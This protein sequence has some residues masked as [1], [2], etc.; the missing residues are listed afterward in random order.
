MAPE[1]LR[2][3][4]ADARSDV[5]S[6][7]VVLHHAVSGALPFQGA[8]G[9][10]LSAAILRE[11][12]AALPPTAPPALRSVLQRCL[13]KDPPQRYQTASE[14]RAALDLIGELSSGSAVAAAP[15]P[16]RGRPLLVAAAAAVVALL[17]VAAWLLRPPRPA[18]PISHRL[19]SVFPGSHSAATFSPDG[20]MIAFL[21]DASGTPQVWVKH[22]SQGDPIQI[23]FGDVPATRP[24]WSPGSDQIVFGRV[25]QGIWSVPP[26][27]GPPRRILEQGS[28]PDLSRDGSRLV[29]ERGQEIW[30]ARPDGSE[31]R[32]VDVS[33]PRFY[34]VDAEPALSPDGSQI[35][36]FHPEAGPAGDIRVVP[37]EGGTSRRLTSGMIRPAR[38]PVW[39]PD[40]RWILYSSARAGSQTLWR[41]AASGGTPEPVTV[42]P[43][44]DLEPAL[45]ADG[46]RVI[47]TNLRR[48]WKLQ[49]RDNPASA[50]RELLERRAGVS[51]PTFSPAG[52]R[53]AFFAV[54]D[55]GL[56]VFTIGVDGKDLRQVTTS[57]TFEANIM[58]A[59]SGDASYLYYYTMFPSRS[60]RKISAAGG[61]SSEV[62]PWNFEKQLGARP[63]PTDG[64]IAYAHMEHRAT[65]IW[66]PA[67][68]REQRIGPAMFGVRWSPDGRSISGAGLDGV[69]CVCPV[70]E[71][72]CTPLSKGPPP[73][74]TAWSADG[75]RIYFLRPARAPMMREL[76]SVNPDTRAEAKVTEVGPF[77]TLDA[78]FDVSAQGRVVS[79]ALHESR[80]ELW[81]AE[82]P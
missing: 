67:T 73:T 5:W 57:S 23:T 62:A 60:F 61:A 12:P 33:P 79:T 21:S 30:I 32:R 80:H 54:I 16:A 52:D 26:L 45:A 35:A 17:A 53:L 29:F 78:F 22:L 27:G 4:S 50:P 13:A 64:R 3:E 8:S 41:V 20:N 38:T 71:E 77:T 1:V 36:F 51:F 10:D 56:H 39:T 14:V 28:N 15:A 9:F 76:W 25:G 46:R 47:Y 74:P 37:V 2:G 44:E 43:G 42:G 59:W 11:P 68:G 69:I 72:K 63:H 34:P 6:L 7:G 19:I 82:L 75:S 18:T 65:V 66:D 55:S 40:G 31:P 24:R 49:V 58:P 81:L 48:S 70:T